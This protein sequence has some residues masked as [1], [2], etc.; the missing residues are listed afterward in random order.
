MLLYI[1]D[2]YNLLHKIPGMRRSQTPQ[3]DLIA[4]IRKHR[5]IG[6]SRNRALICFDGYPPQGYTASHDFKIMFSGLDSADD[7]IRSR[8]DNEPNPAK[9]LVVT[10]DRQIRD[11]ARTKKVSSLYC[12]EFL[13]PKPVAGKE[14]TK[15][16]SYS[17][18]SEITEEM[19][20]IWSV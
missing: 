9:I 8:V 18:Q 15:D 17:L 20:K 10:D 2:G 11:Y 6:S 1:I 7:L 14:N 5:L 19:R 4:Y 12:R 16:I 13:C 3:A